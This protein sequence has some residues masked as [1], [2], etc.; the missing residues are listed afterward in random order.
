MG[1]HSSRIVFV[2]CHSAALLALAVAAGFLS[3]PRLP[4]AI[5]RGLGAYCLERRVSN[6]SRRRG[7]TNSMWSE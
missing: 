7:C 6:G 4:E 2:D 1:V 5:D 3:D